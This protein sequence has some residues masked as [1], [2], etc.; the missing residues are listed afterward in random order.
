MPAPSGLVFSADTRQLYINNA[1]V[2][3]LLRMGILTS[4]L[5]CWTKACLGRRLVVSRRLAVA[6]ANQA[7]QLLGIDERD[8]TGTDQ[9]R[10]DFCSFKIHAGAAWQ[11]CGLIGTLVQRCPVNWRADGVW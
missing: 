11:R 7:D 2:D 1:G 4:E 3:R 8:L 9:Q 5:R 10:V 6:V